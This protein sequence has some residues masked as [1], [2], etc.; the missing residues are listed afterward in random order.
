ME[1]PSV[2]FVADRVE[3]AGEVVEA[4]SP[5]A[6][7]RGEP[8][9]DRPQGFRSHAVETPLGIAADLDET[10]LAEDPQMLGDGRLAQLELLDKLP[11]GTLAGAQQI[12]DLATVRLRDDLEYGH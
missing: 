7:V 10:R 11:D 8:L 9:V 4:G 3:M 2:A 6:P 5:H 1:P 12:E